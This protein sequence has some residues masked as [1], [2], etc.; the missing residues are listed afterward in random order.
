MSESIL[1][2]LRTETAA[3]HKSLE[4]KVGIM[5]CLAEVP[6]YRDLL[7]RF[8]G[9]YA[10]MEAQLESVGDW[11]TVGLDLTTRRKA[12]WIES[13]L[14][15]LGEAPATLPAC[16]DLAPLPTIGHAFGALYVLEGSTLGGRTIT[17]MMNGSAI[18]EN[19]RRFFA[20]YEA[21][22]GTKWKEFGAALEKYVAESGR[23]DDVIAG[24]NTVFSSMER[25]MDKTAA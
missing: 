9:F 5:E 1:S 4:D 18:P 8:H 13:D 21:E 25:W 23:G 20:G 17:G 2:R 3:A 19:A 14:A 12:A 24:A 15:A 10:P 22:T 16:D 6:Q 7:V 11:S